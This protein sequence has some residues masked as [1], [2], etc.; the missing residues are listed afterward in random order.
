M[1]IGAKAL[2]FGTNWC[3]AFGVKVTTN[4]LPISEEGA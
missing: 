3:G 4:P 2:W 1:F